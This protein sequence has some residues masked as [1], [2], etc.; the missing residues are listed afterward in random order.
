[1]RIV[2]LPPREVS[3]PAQS[4]WRA[5]LDGLRACGHEIVDFGIV[6]GTP[7]ALVTLNDQPAARAAIARHDLRPA[8]AALVVLEPPVTSPSMYLPRSLRRYAHRFAASPHWASAIGGEAFRWPQSLESGQC[9]ARPP[10]FRATMVN[11]DKRSAIQGSLYGLRR[12][13]IRACAQHDVGLGLFGPGWGDR[14]VERGVVGTRCMVRA[15]TSRRWP[16]VGEAFG[17]LSFRP[18]SW[19]GSVDSKAAALSLA[20]IAIVIENSAD[21]VSEKLVDAVCA[22]AAPVYVGPALADFDLPDDIA[23]RVEPGANDIVSAVATASDGYIREVR[24]AGAE[25]L[26]SPGARRHDITQVLFDLGQRIGTR[27]E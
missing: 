22:G 9:P 1:M 8:R 23:I 6:S 25:W 12:S 14:A 18:A 15:M 3:F 13:V 4:P 17:D 19:Q 7:D 24:Q 26:R 20:P 2:V 21:Y 16:D 11:G 5:V 10:A 27:L